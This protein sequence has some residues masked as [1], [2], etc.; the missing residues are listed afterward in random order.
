MTTKEIVP[1]NYCIFLAL[2]LTEPWP[3][4]GSLCT[5]PTVFD[6]AR[7]FKASVTARLPFLSL[8]LYTASVKAFT[9]VNAQAEELKG[10]NMHHGYQPSPSCAVMEPGTEFK[11]SPLK[12]HHNSMIRV[13]ASQLAIARFSEYY[14]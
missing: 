2:N 14:Y 7:Y 13:S 5:G 10:Y 6:Q 8:S 12:A 3:G 9:N 1:Y 4:L 11:Y